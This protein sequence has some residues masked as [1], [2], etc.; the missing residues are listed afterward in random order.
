MQEDL[1]K[2][3]TH[4]GFT[5]YEAKAY[6]ALLHQSPLTG[7]AIARAS[8]VPR[9]KI[10]EVLGSLVE[11]GDVL[12]SHGEPVQYTPKQPTELIASRRRTVEQQFSAAEQGL[13]QFL[14]QNIPNDLIWD[15][16]GRDEI[17]SRL[18]EV[19]GRAKEQI[20][21]QI[22]EEDVPAIREV[23]LKAAK[24]NVAVTL[25]AYG[26]PDL[27]FAR[28]YKHEPGAEEITSE[29]GGRWLILSIDGREIVAGIVSMGKDSR[30]AW[31]SHLGI[32]MP[33]TEQIK[34]DLYIAEMLQK[35]RDILEASFGPALRDLRKQ[36][37]PATTVYRPDKS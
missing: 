4:L 22:W 14:S 32:V 28:V 17:L 27:P 36:F 19:I 10:Y 24:R 3:L 13:E 12:V 6:L 16:R 34:H 2:L 15:I 9:S 18:C 35:H 1:S 30:A 7:Y 11:R 31:S 20:L 26:E 21:L 8:G 5:E 29:Y 37:G 33:I 23:L 25:V